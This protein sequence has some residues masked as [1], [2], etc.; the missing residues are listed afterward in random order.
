MWSHWR[1]TQIYKEN[2]PRQKKF[3]SMNNK[4]AIYGLDQAQRTAAKVAGILYL[5]TIVT[6]N[7]AEFYVRRPLIVP[8]DAAQT[9]TNIAEHQQLFRIGITSD[10]IMLAANVMLVVALYVVLKPVSKNLALL[11]VFWRLVECSIAAASVAIDFAALLLLS[12]AGSSPSSN[13]EQQAL[14]RLLV[15]MDTG[16]NLV[17][18]LFFGLGSTVFC[19][20]WFKSRYIPRLLA[21]WGILASLVPTIAPLATIALSSLADA[22]LRRARAGTPILIFEVVIGLWLLIKGINAP[23]QNVPSS[24]FGPSSPAT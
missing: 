8:G 24:S 15:S 16:G 4:M 9:A 23:L 12:G 6:A 14:A 7:L 20:L 11:A 10:L 5:F 19:Y 22:P 2:R 18:A 1:H 21:A 3:L 17:A 13:S